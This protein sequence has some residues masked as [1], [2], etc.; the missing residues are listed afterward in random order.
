MKNIRI[1]R[2]PAALLLAL[3]LLGLAAC[4]TAPDPAPS[5]QSSPDPAERPTVTVCM[6]LDVGA[7]ET[8]SSSSLLN[9]V[10]EDYAPEFKESYKLE[11]DSVPG[12]GPNREP[13]LDHIRVELMSGGGA[14]LYLCRTPRAAKPDLIPPRER[15][16]GLFQ[17]PKALMERN[18]FLPLDDYIKNAKYMEWD[19]LYP[20]IM[21]AGKNGKGQLILPIGWSMDFVCFDPESY[22]PTANLPMTFEEMLQSDD[23][24]IREALSIS[25]F[26]DSLGTVADYEND[27]PCFTEEELLT[28]LEATRENLERRT[29][30]LEK[31]LGHHRSVNFGRINAGLFCQYYQD[32]VLIPLYNRQGGATAFITSFGAVNINTDVPEGAFEVLELLLSKEVQKDSELLS[33]DRGAPVHMELLRSNKKGRVLAPFDL[34]DGTYKDRWGLNDHNYDQLQELVKQITVVDFPTPVHHELQELWMPYQEA[35]T[36]EEREKLVHDAYRTITM[37]LAES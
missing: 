5:S 16:I 13:A 2:N 36:Q 32:S 10:I 12:S 6:D 37:M 27:V 19:K 1:S 15:Q 34:P 20:Q 21:E 25:N 8:Y 3:L 17:Y 26:W 30:E 14:D 31:S 11:I 7:E 18:M 33:Y 24:G 35:Q 22:T 29:P 9:D 23:P 28:H 4:R